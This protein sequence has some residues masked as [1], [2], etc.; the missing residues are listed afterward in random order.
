MRD[1]KRTDDEDNNE[2]R[3]ND[4]RSEQEAEE[5]DEEISDDPVVE[6]NGAVYDPA[7]QATP[8]AER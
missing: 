4:K 5:I 6:E 7:A 2:D 1:A 3:T 8:E